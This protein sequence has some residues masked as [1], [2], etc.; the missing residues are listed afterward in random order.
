VDRRPEGGD[1][2]EQSADRRLVCKVNVCDKVD[3]S[4]LP[5][6]EALRLVFVPPRHVASRTTLDQS[7][8]DGGPECAGAARHHNMPTTEIH[9]TTSTE[10]ALLMLDFS[11]DAS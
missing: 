3:L 9:V 10:L 5:I 6:A 8:H 11:H 2:T 7:R 1:A 4:V